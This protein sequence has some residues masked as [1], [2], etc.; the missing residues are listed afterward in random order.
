MKSLN[1]LSN[2][3]SGLPT[4]TIETFAHG[5]RF[6]RSRFREWNYFA[7]EAESRICNPAPLSA[8]WSNPNAGLA[9]A[10]DNRQSPLGFEL[11]NLAVGNHLRVEGVNNFNYFIAEDQFWPNPYEIGNAADYQSENE[12]EEHLY[13]VC[14]DVEAVDHKENNEYESSTSPR[15][16]T[17]RSEGFGHMPSIA[18]DRR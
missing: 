7:V 5:F 10:M 4:R 6:D 14:S 3:V 1:S 2:Q 15:V 18:G 17:S 9:A 13:G 8:G 11:Q 12:F 16:I